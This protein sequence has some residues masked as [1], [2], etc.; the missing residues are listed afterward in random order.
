MTSSPSTGAR[1]RR[2]VRRRRRRRVFLPVVLAAAAITLGAVVVSGGFERSEPRPPLQLK[3]G[4]I[5]DQGRFR[6]EFVA[7]TVGQGQP[8]ISDPLR[9]VLTVH[10]KVT[11]LSDRTV[12]VQTLNDVLKAGAMAQTPR[13]AVR[14]R[15]GLSTQLHP[16]LMARVVLAYELRSGATPPTRLRVDVGTYE[17]R[18]RSVDAARRWR[19][20]RKVIAQVLLTP[21]AT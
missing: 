17:D 11:N 10:L 9:R 15:N 2:G 5:V 3:R 6:T 21:R 13:V 12:P 18:G 7:A 14:G 8:G 4:A 20:A 19:P 16:N 1:S